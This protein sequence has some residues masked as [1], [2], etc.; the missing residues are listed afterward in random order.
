MMMPLPPQPPNKMY[1]TQEAHTAAATSAIYLLT[2]AAE[3][4]TADDNA[5]TSALI[6][7]PAESAVTTEAELAGIL[8]LLL[9]V[10]GRVYPVT[11]IIIRAK[12]AGIPAQLQV[13]ECIYLHC[14]SR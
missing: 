10:G 12:V 7:P 2:L 3:S 8:E 4:G 5:N 9:Q 14:Q 1:A 6:D 13:A 11:I